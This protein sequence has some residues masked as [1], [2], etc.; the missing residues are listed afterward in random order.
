[1]ER[2]KV[3]DVEAIVIPEQP[4]DADRQAPEIDLGAEQRAFPA[5]HGRAKKHGYEIG[6]VMNLDGWCQREWTE[7]LGEIAV[8]GQADERPHENLYR[9]QARAKDKQRNVG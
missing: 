7:Y 6:F 4:A 9:D 1:M 5:I 8:V 3:P 2:A